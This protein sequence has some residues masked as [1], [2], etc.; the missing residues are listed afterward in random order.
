MEL[1]A[2]YG[3]LGLWTFSLLWMNRQQYK[4]RQV[5]ERIA[6]KALQYHQERIVAS[7]MRQE[8]MLTTALDKINDGLQ[9]IRNRGS[10]ERR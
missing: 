3:P 8:H 7:L 4:D 6:D 5:R 1:L 2:Q 9:E 10:R